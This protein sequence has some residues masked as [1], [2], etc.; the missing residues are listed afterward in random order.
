MC[1]D[2]RESFW[3]QPYCS[4]QWHCQ[5]LGQLCQGDAIV[6]IRF[7]LLL[8]WSCM[9]ALN[10]YNRFFLNKGLGNAKPFRWA[11]LESA[12]LCTLG[13]YWKGSRFW[14]NVIKAVITS[15]LPIWIVLHGTI[16]TCKNDVIT[17]Q[18]HRI[19][20]SKLGRN[21]QQ[22]CYYNLIAVHFEG[23]ATLPACMRSLQELAMESLPYSSIS[24]VNVKF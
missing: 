9:E 23:K 17:I 15:L 19:P 4:C 3:I 13:N 10:I 11:F 12:W 8:W 7:S 20:G 5:S 1:K 6:I 18:N 24:R 21:F 2:S 22:K 14:W 16:Q